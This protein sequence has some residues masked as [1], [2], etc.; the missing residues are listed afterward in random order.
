MLSA[1]DAKFVIIFS[2][3]AYFLHFV[4]VVRT[5]LFSFDFLNYH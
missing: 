3:L 2:F 5:E 4:C 1:R